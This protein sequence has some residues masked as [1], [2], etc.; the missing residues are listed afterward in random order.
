[1]FSYAFGYKGIGIQAMN[2]IYEIGMAYPDLAANFGFLTG[3]AYTIPFAFM[4]LFYGKLTNKVNRKV[5][6]G[7]FMALSGLTMGA[8]GFMDSFLVLYASRFALGIIGAMFNPMSFSLLTDYF[9]PERRATANSVIQSGNYIGWGLSSI[10]I[11]LIQQFGWRSTFGILGAAGAVIGAIIIAFVK[12][13][14]QKMS[15]DMAKN[16]EAA[17][18]DKAKEAAAVASGEKEQAGFKELI[19]NPVNRWVLTGSFFRNFGGSIT[20]YYLPVFFLKNFAAYK[21][22]YSFVNSVI[23]SLVGLA[24][25]IIGGILADKYEKKTPWIKALIPIIGSAASVPLIAIATMQ[26]NFWISM[27]CFTLFTLLSSAFSGPAI[28]MMQNTTEKS[29]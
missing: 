12:E 29:L 2:P 25:G 20:T 15:A 26:G 9:P 16:K 24:S 3:F 27:V 6:L 7:I 21:V 11:I 22:Q 18:A 23:L 10:S 19:A 13:P 14:L 1:M 17:D 8:A 28:T 4:G 5:V